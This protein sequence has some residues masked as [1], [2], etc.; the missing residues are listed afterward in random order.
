[1]ASGRQLEGLLVHFELRVLF[2][3]VV[4]R[5]FV[6]EEDDGMLELIGAETHATRDD[7]G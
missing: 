1:M 3:E 4:H 5:P 2:G 6:R 7:D